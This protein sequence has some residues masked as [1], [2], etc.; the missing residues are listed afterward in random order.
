MCTPAQLVGVEIL[1]PKKQVINRSE[2]SAIAYVIGLD[3]FNRKWATL[4]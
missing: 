4:W 3:G 2:E 1:V